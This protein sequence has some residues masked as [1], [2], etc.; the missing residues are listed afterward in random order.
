MCIRD[1]ANIGKGQIFDPNG[2]EIFKCK[3]GNGQRGGHQQE[4]HDLFADIRNGKLPNEGEYGAK[5]TFTA[6]FG[7][8]ATYSGKEISWDDAINSDISLCNVDALKNMNDVAPVQPDADGRYPI[9]VP[10]KGYK[11]VIDWDLKPKKKKKT[12]KKE[13]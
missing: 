6:I 10:G 11:D 4:H 12:K 2:K 8:M 5:S 9:P 13:A 1:S 3:E 7:R